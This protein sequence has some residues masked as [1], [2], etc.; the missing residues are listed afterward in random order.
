MCGG[1]GGGGGSGGVVVVVCVCVCMRACVY[2][3]SDSV[4]GPSPFVSFGFI[5]ISVV[6]VVSPGSLLFVCTRYTLTCACR[7]QPVKCTWY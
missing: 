2:V 4:F 1:G 5:I 7:R 6:V 3:S